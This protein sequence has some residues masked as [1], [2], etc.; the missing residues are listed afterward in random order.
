MSLA[1]QNTVKTANKISRIDFYFVTYFYSL[2]DICMADGMPSKWGIRSF[3]F[4][5]VLGFMRLWIIQLWIDRIKTCS[6]CLH[7]HYV[8][9]SKTLLHHTR[10]RKL[11]FS[12]RVSTSASGGELGVAYG[13]S[14]IGGDA[15]NVIK[16]VALFGLYHADVVNMGVAGEHTLQSLSAK[17]SRAIINLGDD[18]SLVVI[19]LVTFILDVIY[20]ITLSL[21]IRFIKKLLPLDEKYSSR[22]RRSSSCSASAGFWGQAGW[23]RTGLVVAGKRQRLAQIMPC[24]VGDYLL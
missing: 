3:E 24:H 15:G 23:P 22:G 19:S 14:F 11:P 8:F 12:T 13:A 20:H 2:Y 5:I 17:I 7:V 9:L 16:G 6:S 4:W 10:E 21:S 18:P 1:R